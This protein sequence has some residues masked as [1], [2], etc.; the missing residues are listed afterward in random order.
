MAMDLKPSLGMHQSLK[1][2][3]QLQQAIKILQLSR[4]ELEEYITNELKENPT[5]EEGV[6]ESPEEKLQVE[7]EAERTE[8]HVIQE[9]A[10]QASD[11]V[12]K[13]SGDKEEIDWDMM[14]Q[15]RD[16]S[17]NS[18]TASAVRRQQDDELPNYENIVTK[19]KTLQEHLMSQVGELDFSES[20]RNLSQLLIGNIDDRGY[21]VGDLQEITNSMAMDL[22][23]AEGVLDT[24]QRFDPP[25]VGA[26]DLKECLLIQLRAGGL[27]NGIV[28]VIV[29]N[30][31]HELENR[32]YQ[33]IAKALKIP[34]EKVFDNVKV[35]GE[36]EPVPGRQFIAEATQYVTPDVYVF[37]LGTDWVVTL[38]EDGLPRLKVSPFYKGMLVKKE[39]QGDD[40][41]YIKDKLQAADWLIKSIQQRQRTIFKVAECIVKRQ[42]DFFDHGATF[43]KPM[44]LKD[45]ADEVGVHE[46]TVSRVTNNK[47]MHTHRGIFELKYFFNS[48]VSTTGGDDVASEAVKQ[49]IQEMVKV[50]DVKHPLSDQDLVGLLEKRG[51]TVARRTVAKYREQLGVLSSSRRKKFF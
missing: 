41:K 34:L 26:R 23:Q 35:I 31:L 42:R 46:S 28:E 47:Y 50:E 12:D 45:V 44:I 37:K 17:S 33:V 22:D 13:V 25:G 1:I 30:H 2:T 51:I 43:L 10:Q 20:E 3:P 7:R 49:I 9:Q 48:K 21:F 5:L 16:S 8:D 4:M 27:K 38:N 40:K 15:L 19:S 36:L 39:A 29:E 11:L 14:G 24:I 32:N 6:L 18:P